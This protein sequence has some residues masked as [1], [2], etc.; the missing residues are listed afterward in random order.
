MR[1]ITLYRSDWPRV[2][3]AAFLD[4]SRA[5]LRAMAP[6]VDLLVR[7]SLAKAFFAPGMLPGGDIGGFH[8]TWPM[9]AARV[10]G[11]VLLAAGFLV[12]PLAL[13]MLVLTLLAQS[14]GT[15]QDEH[16]FWATLFGWYV[17]QGAGPLSLDHILGKGLT[18]SP[19]PLAG[20]AMAAQRWVSREVGPFYLLAIRLWLAV[21]LIGPVTMHSMLPTMEAGMLPRPWAIA[22]AALLALGLST[23]VVAAGLLVGACGTAIAD[24]DQGMTIYGPLLLAMLAVFGAGRYSLDRLIIDWAHRA[25]PA[26]ESAPHVVIVGA[27]FGGMACAARLGHERAQVTLIDRHNYHLFQPLLYQVATAALSPADIATPIRGVFRDN[28]RLRVLCGT[29]TA[30]DVAA[31]RLIVDGRAVAY[32]ALVLATGA[33]HGYFGREEWAAYAPGLKSVQDATSIRSRILD[34]FEQAEATD[35]PAA[36]A[37]LLTFLIV[38]AGPTGVE[39]A[40][41]IAEL[42]RNGMAKDFRNFDPASARILLVQAGPRVLPQFNERLSA[43]ARTSL[44]ALGVEVRVDSRVEGIDAEGV[45]VS[46]ERI[47]A[48]TALWAAGVVASPAAAWLGIEPDRA[49]RI[50]VGPDLSVPGLPDVFAIGDTALALAWNGQPAPG[51][52]PAAKQGGAYVAAVLRARMSNRKP[53]PPF[54]YRHQGSLATIG[55]KSAVADFG[56]LKLTGA[57]AWWLWGAVHVMF[58]LGVRNRLSVI[59]GWVWSYFTFDVGV[60]LITDEG[61]RRLSPSHTGAH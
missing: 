56:R 33:T 8:A 50:K 24:A 12:R 36:R 1:P 42:A 53:P 52:A 59:L 18:H 60:R 46:G 27:G 61:T 57:A 40:G 23:P 51:L 55:R 49:G 9:I 15:P 7:L 41:A 48:S 54:R 25:F 22:S 47:R 13:L 5:A 38:G 2:R 35:D 19:L 3:L 29:V 30:V 44:E 17:V 21:A 28:P 43:F 4:I 58:L 14:L 32:D 20:P 45:V 11:P 16:L 10:T 39:M 34:A 31:R 37:S 6:I 26:D